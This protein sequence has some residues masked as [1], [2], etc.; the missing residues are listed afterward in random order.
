MKIWAVWGLC[1]L[2][3]GLGSCEWFHSPQARTRQ[4]VDAEMQG[5]DW[6]QLDQFPLFDACD[7]TASKAGQQ[8]CFQNTL[9][10][11]LSMALQDFDFRSETSLHDTIYVDFLVDN[12]GGISVMSVDEN[13]ALAAENPEFENIV[14]RSLRSLPRLQPA[15][16]RG[17]PVAARFRLPLVVKTDE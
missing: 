9:T 8:E 5:I 3:L 13:R 7:E 12:Q 14:S 10:R 16:K 4:L 11:H 1:A 2:A 17:I 6:N 15:L